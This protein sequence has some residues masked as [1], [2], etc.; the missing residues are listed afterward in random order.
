MLHLTFSLGDNVVWSRVI[1][2][3]FLL[4]ASKTEFPT[5]FAETLLKYSELTLVQ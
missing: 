4:V 5:E 3:T 1:S 2:D